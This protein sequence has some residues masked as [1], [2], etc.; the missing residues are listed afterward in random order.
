MGK[1][2]K[3][4]GKLENFKVIKKFSTK[5]QGRVPTQKLEKFGNIPKYICR[6]CFNVLREVRES[7]RKIEATK[8]KLWGNFGKLENF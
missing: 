4:F 3:N 7:G 5:F 1:L 2:W 6:K 8:G